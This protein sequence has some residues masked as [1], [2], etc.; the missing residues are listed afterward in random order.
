M[1]TCVISFALAGI[2]WGVPE[3]GRCVAQ[4]GT[5]KYKDDNCT[6]KAGSHASEKAFEFKKGAPRKSFKASGGEVVLATSETKIVCRAESAIGEYRET[7]GAI[8]GV[9]KL[10]MR[11]TGCSLPSFVE[12]E[13][14]GAEPE[15]F[16]TSS[17]KGSFGYI[18]GE[19]TKT[20][21]VGIKLQPEKAKGPF[22]EYECGRGAV[23]VKLGVSAKTPN[24]N[25]CTIGT[26]SPPNLMSTS[27][28]EAFS[29]SKGVQS[30]QSFQ[31]TPTK[32]CNLEVS[33]N[34]GAYERAGL[35]FESTITNEEA[36][37]IKA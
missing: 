26:L 34:G 19:K 13:T 18:S 12:C 27:F 29:Q 32:I 23:L 33:A 24:G 7:L 36:L 15:E 2:A 21:V 30:P 31:S 14:K 37:E 3:V 22:L 25:D 16:V 28:N 9:Q 35:G 1:S 20:P 11:F 10:V 6:Q 4:P 5:G 8:T 17:L